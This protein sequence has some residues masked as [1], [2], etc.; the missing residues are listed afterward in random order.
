MWVVVSSDVFFDLKKLKDKLLNFYGLSR[1]E[2]HHLYSKTLKAMSHEIDE[3][4]VVEAY[5]VWLKADFYKEMHLIL[6]LE[7]LRTV[8]KTIDVIDYY[9]I[10]PFANS[11]RIFQEHLGLFKKVFIPQEYKK[12]ITDIYFYKIVSTYVLKEAQNNVRKIR[13]L[14]SEPYVCKNLIAFDIV[15]KCAR[16]AEMA[17]K[18][19][20]SLAVAE[21]ETSSNKFAD[22][23]KV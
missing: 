19:L 5:L 23:K 4:E 10:S 1:A 2:A 11:K 9:L 17:K 3:K 16:D 13:A 12:K 15:A 7:M 22:L 18:Y 21:K 8:S 20:L 14:S 6:N